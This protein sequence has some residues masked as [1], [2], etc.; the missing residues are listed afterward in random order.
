MVPHLPLQDKPEDDAQS[1][2]GASTV[3]YGDSRVRSA[4]HDS[5][6]DELEEEAEE[7]EA[8]EEEV[9]GGEAREGE[10]V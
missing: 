8:E 6:G 10:E 1:A 5:G 4:V 9:E 2:G 7:E 3:T